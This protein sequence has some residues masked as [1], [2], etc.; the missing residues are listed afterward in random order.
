VTA[1]LVEAQDL[2]V[3]YRAEGGGTVKAV[4]GVSF[5]IQRGETL[6]LVGESGCGKSSLGRALLRL[7]PAKSGRVLFDG[8]DISALSQSAL[9]PLRRRMQLVFQ[10]PVASLNPRMT[11]GAI[12]SEALTIHGLFEGPARGPRVAELLEQVGLRPD[13]ANRHPHEFSGGQR[14]RVGIARAL[15]VQPDFVV[16][17]EPVSAL[18]VSIQAQIINLLMEL[19]HALS[20][21]FLFIAHD[22]S[23][24]RHLS[25]RVG[26]MY[27]GHVVELA[28]AAQIFEAPLHPYTQALLASVPRLP[29]AP[30]RP[31]TALKGDPP[32]PLQPPAGCPF[33]P[34]CPVAVE[35]CQTQR[36][37]LRV[38][39]EGQCVACHLQGG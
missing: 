35:R 19:Q 5:S 30:P 6:G 32:S 3:E 33:H 10:D 22:L 38:V 23:V 14:Q 17:D 7:E 39:G 21:T 4:G 29:P 8:Q 18:D 36:P 1:P 25:H 20:L 2:T 15:A 11:V 27:L 34:R 16:L 26:V 9:R 12:L 13:A 28:S 37:L 24:V 31:R